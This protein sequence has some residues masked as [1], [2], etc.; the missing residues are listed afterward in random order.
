M[1]PLQQ[2]LDDVGADLSQ[3]RMELQKLMEVIQE[4]DAAIESLEQ[5]LKQ[6]ADGRWERW[7]RN[8]FHCSLGLMALMPQ[9]SLKRALI[10]FKNMGS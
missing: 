7:L 1:V 9:S 5:Q 10:T 8:E 3:M 4:K 6:E 2:S